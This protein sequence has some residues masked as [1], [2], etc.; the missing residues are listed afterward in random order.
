MKVK[1]LNKELKERKAKFFHFNQNNSGGSFVE[2]N[3]A[4]ITTDVIIEAFDAAEANEKAEQ[5]GIYFDG[6][7][8]EIDC[9][10]CGDR[11]YPAYDEGDVEPM[12]HG[13]SLYKYGIDNFTGFFEYKV[14][15]HYL[16]GRID[17]VEM[18]KP[19]QIGYKK[20]KKKKQKKLKA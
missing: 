15:I 6:C 17:K 9:P 18:K 1:V 5:I 14:F 20:E 7:E 2:D 3:E 13:R 19:D 4:G 11:W 12:M 16:N 8:K 10:C